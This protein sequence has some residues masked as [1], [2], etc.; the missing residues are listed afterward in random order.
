MLYNQIGQSTKRDRLFCR[1]LCWGHSH[2]FQVLSDGR[3]WPCWEEKPTFI[4]RSGPLYAR[5]KFNPKWLKFYPFWTRVYVLKSWSLRTG[6]KPRILTA[7]FRCKR[8]ILMSLTGM[9]CSLPIMRLTCTLWFFW[10]QRKHIPKLW[11][12]SQCETPASVI[13]DSIASNPPSEWPPMATVPEGCDV[14][15]EGIGYS[16]KTKSMEYTVW[17]GGFMISV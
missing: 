5:Q 9:K 8:Y 17:D 14:V 4:R 6:H 2:D 3:V 15:I 12:I 11:N 16:V 10:T 13:A 1:V 7:S